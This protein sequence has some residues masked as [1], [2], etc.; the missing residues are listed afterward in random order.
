MPQTNEQRTL[1]LALRR[2]Q[3]TLEA[4]GKATR[5]TFGL[6]KA[7]GLG[8]SIGAVWMLMISNPAMAG[9]VGAIALVNYALAAMKETEKTGE[10]RPLLGHKSFSSL[11]MGLDKESTY[12]NPTQTVEDDALYLEDRDLGEWLL[13]RTAM[14]PCI[15]FLELYSEEHRD[16]VMDLAAIEAYRQYGYMFRSEPDTRHQMKAESVGQYAFA[17]VRAQD[18][19]LLDGPTETASSDG[20]GM[21]TRLG[22]VEIPSEPDEEPE[23]AE[24]ERKPAVPAPAIAPPQ[25][26]TVADAPKSEEELAKEFRDWFKGWA[27]LLVEK[28]ETHTRIDFERLKAIWLKEHKERSVTE[29]TQVLQFNLPPGGTIED[30]YVYLKKTASVPTDEYKGTQVEAK[31]PVAKSMRDRVI[32]GL[33]GAGMIDAQQFVDGFGDEKS[34]AIKTLLSLH[35]EGKITKDVKKKM[36]MLNA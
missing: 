14:E 9:I 4:T 27:S 19:F 15:R 7:V 10:W 28:S 33:A 11:A 12:P 21:N 8:G 5:K 18:D 22:A 31:V 23:Q 1:H 34:Q 25:P 13:L 6:G 30:G 3:A 32:E 35:A 17:A 26:I 20:I 24:P 2:R 16:E 36:V 29:F